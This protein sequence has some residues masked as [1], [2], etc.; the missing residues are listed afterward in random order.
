MGDLRLGIGV[1][2]VLFWCLGFLLCE[3][4]GECVFLGDCNFVVGLDFLGDEEWE[5]FVWVH[6][7][8]VILLFWF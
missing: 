2:I 6:F 8:C 3:E 1:R 5:V 7:V 4:W